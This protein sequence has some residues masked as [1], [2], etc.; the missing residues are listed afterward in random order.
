[1][2]SGKIAVPPGGGGIKRSNSYFHMS[3]AVRSL[4]RYEARRVSRVTKN[5]LNTYLKTDSARILNNVFRVRLGKVLKTIN[6]VNVN[7]K[8]IF[9]RYRY[10]S[11]YSQKMISPYYFGP[12]VL[13]APVYPINLKSCYYSIT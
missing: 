13:I 11:Y 6:Y 4:F 2:Y 10:F 1:M 5:R 9:D 3:G 7:F 12:S 8:V